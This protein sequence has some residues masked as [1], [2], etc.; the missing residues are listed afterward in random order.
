MR[1]RDQHH[2]VASFFDEHLFALEAE[3][4]WKPDCLA[5]AILKQFC[6]FYDDLLIN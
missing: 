5:L 3:F 2:H 6:G 4:L 1:N